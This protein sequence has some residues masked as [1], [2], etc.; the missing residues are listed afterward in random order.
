MEKTI[1]T[2][3]ARNEEVLHRDKEE[4]NILQT[5]IGRKGKWIG[6]I[7]CRNCILKDVMEGKI[8]GKI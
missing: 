3:Q 5:I 8:V 1:S 4:R 7:L 2:E 6:H